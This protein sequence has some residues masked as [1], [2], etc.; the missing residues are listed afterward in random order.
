MA[1]AAVDKPD[2][3]LV[4]G[5]YTEPMGHVPEGS[6]AGVSTWYLTAE[7]ELKEA[8]PPAYSRNPS[9]LLMVGNNVYVHQKLDTTCSAAKPP[10]RLS[11]PHRILNQ[12]HRHT[13]PPRYA[14]NEFTEDT[15]GNPVEAAT[16]S[17]FTL[18]QSSGD[19]GGTVALEAVGTPASSAGTAPCN[20]VAP[21]GADATTIVG[22]NY[23]GGN[24]VAL[25][26]DPSGGSLTTEPVQVVAHADLGL[27][28]SMVNPE[29]QEASHPHG[30]FAHPKEPRRI[31]V[32][33]LGCDVVVEHLLTEAG[34]L[35]FVR[36]APAS[37]PGAGPR[38]LAWHPSGDWCVVSNELDNTAA[39]YSY[40][41]DA[42][43]VLAH[44][45]SLLPEGFTDFSSAAD[46]QFSADARFVYASNRGHESI[47]I[48]EL[49]TSGGGSLKVVGH[50]PC[51]GVCPRNFA[52][53]PE[54][55]VMVVANQD[56]HSLEVYSV[57]RDAG[58]L[59]H[60]SSCEVRSPVWVMF[61]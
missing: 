40:T 6:G 15:E 4:V 29:R 60:R 46:I 35:E 51:N 32:P 16:V 27:A 55:D 57:D 31:F 45:V 25:A 22:V 11:P 7:L 18:T 37:S 30:T 56:S 43:M 34:T 49:D 39:L 20:L 8:G 48:F 54:G 17:A 10:P 61:K 59:S 9:A 28:A 24:V 58:T 13:L 42:G 21:G 33:D 3:L 52:L 41:A 14:C 2:R 26:R 38:H 23:C 53:S 36:A 5:T 1:A 44:S 19:A 50:E 12:N 47:A